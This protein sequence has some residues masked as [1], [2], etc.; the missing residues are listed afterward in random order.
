MRPWVLLTGALLAAGTAA[1]VLFVLRRSGRG[2]DAIPSLLEDCEERIRRLDSDLQRA[3][4][5]G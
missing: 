2:D 5:A 3:R 1:A 4:G